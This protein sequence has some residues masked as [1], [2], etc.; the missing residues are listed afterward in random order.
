MKVTSR[1]SL[2]TDQLTG[3]GKSRNPLTMYF[4]T[5]SHLYPR[6][7]AGVLSREYVLRIPSVSQKAKRVPLYSHTRGYGV[8]Q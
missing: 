5:Y 1:M 4:C 3:R 8:K 7:D 2:S 6:E